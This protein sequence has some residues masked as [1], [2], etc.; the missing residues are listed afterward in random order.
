LRSIFTNFLEPI[1]Y[2][3]IT[4]ALLFYLKANNKI[5]IWFLFIFNLLAAVLMFLASYKVLPQRN[6]IIEYDLLLL[7]ASIFINIYFYLTFERKF[8]KK[9]SLIILILGLLNF[10]QRDFIFHSYLQF[11]SIGFYL[12][13]LF[14]IIMVF[15]YFSQVLKRVSNESIFLNFDFWINIAFFIYHLGAIIIFLSIYALSVLV[16]RWQDHLSIGSLW[17][18]QNIFLFFSA[19][20]ITTG[21]IWGNYHRR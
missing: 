12:F 10:I 5:K 15:M 1:S 18:G 4:L 2:C 20:C 17:A 3:I 21:V 14:M 6:N 19:V 9:F 11:D 7:F 16:S 13:S 8:K